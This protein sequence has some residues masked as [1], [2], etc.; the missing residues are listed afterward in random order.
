MTALKWTMLSLV[1]LAGASCASLDAWQAQ[2]NYNHKTGQIDSNLKGAAP[3]GAYNENTG[4]NL[5]S[6]D[7]TIPALLIAG[8]LV[9]GLFVAYPLQR[10]LRLRRES[11]FRE[12]QATQKNGGV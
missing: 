12:W 1:A 9:V 5:T 8:L 7:N 6:G 2:M 4:L 11:K 10:S 3:G